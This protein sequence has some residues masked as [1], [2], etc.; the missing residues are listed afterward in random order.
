MFYTC[1]TIESISLPPFNGTK[2]IKMDS[3][4]TNC[5]SLKEIKM[6]KTPNENFNKLQIEKKR[7]LHS[8][9]TIFLNEN[10]DF[11]LQNNVPLNNN[12]NMVNFHPFQFNNNYIYMNNNN[13][14][15]FQNNNIYMNNNN[16]NDFQ[17]NNIYMNMN[18][19]GFNGFQNN[20]NNNL[21]PN[22][23]LNNN[24]NNN[25]YAYNNIPINFGNMPNMNNMNNINPFMFNNNNLMNQNL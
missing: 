8:V 1:Y 22:I 12:I 23:V 24:I 18:N 21:A 6:W 15:D 13:F 20:Q 16:F 17:N 2:I 5:D 25:Q 9:N 7:F 19:N 3:L 11:I 10:D 14:K 4:F